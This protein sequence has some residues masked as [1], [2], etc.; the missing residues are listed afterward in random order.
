[1]PVMPTIELP[2][3][4]GMANIPLPDRPDIDTNVEI[5]DAPVL[6][7][8]EMDELKQI[9]IPVFEF[10]ELP[11]FNGVPP[12]M[13]SIAV[14]DVFIE[15]KEPEYESEVLDDLTKYISE[16]IKEGGI[17]LPA[18]IEDALFNRARTR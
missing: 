5:P 9:E 12:G 3:A 15:W 1:A 14:P 16:G 8:P 10:P 4:P 7:L 2:S 6:I 13:D 17:G 11:D 18:E